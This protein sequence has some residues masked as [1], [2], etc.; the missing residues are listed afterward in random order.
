MFIYVTLSVLA[1]D[2]LFSLSIF[3]VSCYLNYMKTSSMTLEELTYLL[4]FNSGN[5]STASAERRKKEAYR[6]ELD[7]QMSEIAGD[8]LGRLVLVFCKR[9]VT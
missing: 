6:R 1:G 2:C 7:H 4:D 3:V 5:E 9:T 8:R